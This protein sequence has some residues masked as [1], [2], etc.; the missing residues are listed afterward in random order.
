MLS[1][2]RVRVAR[3]VYPNMLGVRSDRTG[4]SA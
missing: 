1:D 4:V 3:L 2:G